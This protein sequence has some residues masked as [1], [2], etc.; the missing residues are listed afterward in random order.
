MVTST[1][2]FHAFAAAWST[3][4]HPA[5]VASPPLARPAHHD[6]VPRICP[7]DG[8]SRPSHPASL[9]CSSVTYGSMRPPRA[10][11]SRRADHDYP[12]IQRIRAT[13][14]FATTPLCDDHTF[15]DAS[16]GGAS[17]SAVARYSTGTPRCFVALTARTRAR[18]LAK[19]IGALNCAG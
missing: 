19:R 11:R 5:A 18:P 2:L 16:S 10:S 1:P 4:W 12:S 7:I 3:S 14:A 17:G 8:Y 6:L 13:S 9:R 15:A